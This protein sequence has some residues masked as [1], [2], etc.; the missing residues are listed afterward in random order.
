M[1]DLLVP[2]VAL[3]VIGGSATHILANRK[4]RRIRLGYTRLHAMSMA[5]LADAAI[6]TMAVDY[7]ADI[8]AAMEAM[9][10]RAKLRMPSLIGIPH[11]P[12]SADYRKA[13]AHVAKMRAEK[14]AK[15]QSGGNAKQD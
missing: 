11:E 12:T 13:E 3:A 6:E 14:A 8:R 9:L 10:M 7:G 2:L 4:I 5:A 15:E 1:N